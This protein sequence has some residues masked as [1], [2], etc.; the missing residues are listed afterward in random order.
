MEHFFNTAGPCDP[1]KHYML[2]PE[3][4]LPEVERLL[5]REQYFVVHAPRQVGKTTTFRALAQRLTAAGSH[6]ALWSTCEA[7]QSLSADLEGSIDAVIDTLR[8]EAALQLPEALRP[9]EDPGTYPVRT[10]MRG[11]LAAW[12]E[13]SPL[14]VVLFLDEIDALMDDALISLLRQLR[15]GYTARPAAFPASVALIGLRDVRDYRLM[16][17]E[18]PPE[19][20]TLGTSSPFNIKVRSFTLRNF[21]AEEI[22][23]LYDQ[24]TEA[25]GQVW[26]REAVERAFELTQGQPW[27]ANALADQVT[28]H[29]LR[30]RSQPIEVDHV[31]RAREALILRRDT[32]LDSL[33]ARLREPRVRRVL[34]AVL[35]GEALPTDLQDD[36]ITFVEDLGLVRDGQQGLEIANPIYREIIPRALTDTLER[37]VALPRPSYVA[38]DGRLEVDRILDD[39]RE[40]WREHAEEYLARAPYSEAAAQ[41]VFLAFLHKITNGKG[42]LIDR[43]YAAGRGRLDLCIRWPLPGGGF[44]REAIELKVWRDS[45]RFD[46]LAKGKDQLTGYLELLGLERGTLVL[47]DD[48]SDADP[49]PQ[50]IRDEQ[51]EHR[52]FQLRLLW[53]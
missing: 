37:S 17:R 6:A 19:G 45:H 11:F 21:T 38:E 13:R 10:R 28:S 39:F 53:L 49:L 1:G 20:S 40:F 46:V 42:G 48:R 33:V 47:F 52:G 16:A 7:G 14:P 36:D 22:A 23:E 27:L 12:A 2:P 35:A 30:D 32:H 34:A 5:E 24:H 31:E 3:R 51:V 18:E 50:R 41:L 15:S 29:D 9:P 26:T 25:T 4:R 44:Q 43:E 8:Q